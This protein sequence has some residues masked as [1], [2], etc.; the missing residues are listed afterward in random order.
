MQNIKS[1]QSSII[2]FITVLGDTIIFQCRN[3]DENLLQHLH[4]LTIL[5][6]KNFAIQLTNMIRP[7]F[8]IFLSL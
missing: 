3:S 5:K 7:G 8:I 2:Y 6:Y 4:T 1:N